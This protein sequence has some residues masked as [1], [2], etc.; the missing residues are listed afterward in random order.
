ML[1]EML[2]DINQPTT[3]ILSSTGYETYEMHHSNRSYGVKEVHN[4]SKLDVFSA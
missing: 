3:E 4:T 2:N 1:D